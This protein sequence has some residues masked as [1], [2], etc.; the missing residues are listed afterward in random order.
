M[1]GRFSCLP[2][3]AKVSSQYGAPMGRRAV[4][5]RD[6]GPLHCVKVKIDAG[7]YDRGGAYWGAGE[8]LWCVW[9]DSGEVECYL[10]APDRKAAKHAFKLAHG[11]IACRWLK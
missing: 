6:H 10:R 7:G 9:D 11:I 2:F 5:S 1:A 4:Y 3:E 8:P